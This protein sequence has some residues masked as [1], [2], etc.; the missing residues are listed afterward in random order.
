MERRS[1]RTKKPLDALLKQAWIHKHKVQEDVPVW[2]WCLV[3]RK[4]LTLPNPNKLRTVPLYHAD[5]YGEAVKGG[6]GGW[7]VPED[8]LSDDTDLETLCWFS[9]QFVQGEIKK[10]GSAAPQRIVAALE[11]LGQLAGLDQWGKTMQGAEFCSLSDSMVC[12]W[13]AGKWKAKSG[14]LITVLRCLAF[15]CMQF[16]LHPRLFHIRGIDNAIAD[17]LSR[18]KR[19]VM[20]MMSAGNRVRIDID[21]LL[22]SVELGDVQQEIDEMRK[23]LE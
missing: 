15:Q 8:G 9:E 18:Y 10:F 4:M 16:D 7:L 22:Q 3:N 1:E 13:C 23:A 12:V 19:V 20:N 11:C 6:I 2:I 5:A 17:A 14:P 21:A